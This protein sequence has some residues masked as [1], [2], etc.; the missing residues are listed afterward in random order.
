MLLTNWNYLQAMFE[1]S[2][3]LRL[4]DGKVLGRDLIHSSFERNGKCVSGGYVGTMPVVQIWDKVIESQLSAEVLL[5]IQQH[6]FVFSSQ[7]NSCPPCL[8]LLLWISASI[9]KDLLFCR[10]IMEH[11]E[12]HRWTACLHLKAYIQ[13]Y[14]VRDS[15][16]WSVK[17][18]GV[19]GKVSL[20][21]HHTTKCHQE[22]QDWTVRD[23]NG[24][25][26][27]WIG[28][29]WMRF[30]IL[31]LHIFLSHTIDGPVWLEPQNWSECTKCQRHLS[32]T[33]LMGWIWVKAI[34]PH[35]SSNLYQSQ[36]R[37]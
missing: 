30:W 37:R 20:F 8:T 24:R 28:V 29:S 22:A 14:R 12:E 34:I 23:S 25:G 35:P 10:L 16:F 2:D 33:T 26:H 15:T 4:S 7:G 6:A 27:G 3:I 21:I 18:R 36:R 17:G 19:R 32:C 11:F 5:T 1:C 31:S 13:F 9:S